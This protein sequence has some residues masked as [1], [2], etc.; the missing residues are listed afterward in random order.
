MHAAMFDENEMESM[1]TALLK[2][3]LNRLQPRQNSYIRG[4]LSSDNS[5][6]CHPYKLRF[7]VSNISLLG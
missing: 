6:N 5:G 4:F 7:D 1:I 2:P 3:V